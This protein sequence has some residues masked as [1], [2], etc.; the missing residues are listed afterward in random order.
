MKAKQISWE[1]FARNQEII[2]DKMQ[3]ARAISV[4]A[5][6]AER[7]Y[8]PDCFDVGD[9]AG[10]SRCIMAAGGRIPSAMLAVVLSVRGRR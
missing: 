6:F 10:S 5:R 4:A 9:A 1:E 3:T 2:S 7:L 8:C